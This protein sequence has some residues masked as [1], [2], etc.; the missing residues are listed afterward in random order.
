MRAIGLDVHKHFAEVAVVQPGQGVVSRQRIPVTPSELRRF[1]DGL[2]REDQVVLEASFNTWAVADLL[3][4]RAGRVIVSN[5]MRTRAIAS[6][7]V[8]T[9]KV[10]AAVLAQLL[11]ADFIPPV[12]VPDAA[13]RGLRR[14]VAHRH[15]LVAQRT[16]LRNRIH[17]ILSR[18]LVECP[19]TDAFGKAGRR[20]L[21][22][23]R[24]P[25]DE[26][27]QVDSHLRVLMLV[28]QE[29]EQVD[30]SL[31]QEHLTDPRL[32]RLLSLPG[33]GLISALGLLAVVGDVTRFA[34]P[35]RLVGYLG[36]DPRVRQ[37]GD[38][39]AY[40]GHISRQG[41]A[42]A[43]ALL[44]EAAQAAIRVP[45]PLRAFHQRVRARRGPQIAI[46][47]VARKLAVLAWHLLTKDCDY[48]WIR[49]SLKAQKWR[50]VELRA[51]APKGTV[52]GIWNRAPAELEQV[53]LR[54]AE[55]AYRALVT[56]RQQPKDAAAPMR[57]RLEGQRPDARRRSHPL[58]PL[59]S[60]GSTASDNSIVLSPA[61]R[62]ECGA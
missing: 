11:A 45:G 15:G 47:A 42:H 59:F 32:R 52:H 41:Q 51:G 24:L 7:K 58:P 10:D 3:R 12:W 5:P 56:A 6:A 14:R 31:A 17:A 38:R 53:V 1:A 44:V 62:K 33:I 2:E 28:E 25:A 36:L 13:T 37:S 54:Q 9:D 21:G 43:R 61:E 57:K 40:T 35:N 48:Q 26:Q 8:K 34:R 50:Q 23:V 20:W 39:P 19:Y 60:T 4:Q 46:V 30:R 22:M 27:L 18:N 29:I 55:A 16:Q 49:P